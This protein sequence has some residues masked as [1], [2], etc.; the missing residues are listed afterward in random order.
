MIEVPSAI[1]HVS[2]FLTL[3]DFISVGSNDLTQY[4]L[5]V[6]RNNTQ[7]A[8][9]YEPL[10]PGV[11][12]ALK[13]IMEA[14]KVAGKP[15]S[16]CGEMA[17]CPRAVIILLGLGFDSLSMNAYSI[18]K[19]KWVIRHITKSQAEAALAAVLTMRHAKEI[20]EYC[21]GIL[22]EI[23]LGALVRGAKVC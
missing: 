15:V 8:S 20:H 17:G 3:V 9:I 11:I 6:D 21:E 16:I 12:R 18:P 22:E 23:G 2:D 19:V 13:M 7:V 5:A 1:Y 4:L 14:A 10:H